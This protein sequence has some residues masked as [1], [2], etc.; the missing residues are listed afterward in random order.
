MA[1]FELAGTLSV[2]HLANLSQQTRM[3][4]I[5]QNK[6]NTYLSVLFVVDNVA[7][8]VFD[9]KLCQL[10]GQECNFG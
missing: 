10:G 6:I 7:S 3:L 5:G 4:E 1:V 9:D 2:V 8:P